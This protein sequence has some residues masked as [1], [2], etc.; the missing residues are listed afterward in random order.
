MKLIRVDM[1]RVYR[2]L[3]WKNRKSSPPIGVQETRG[4]K[5]RYYARVET[6]GPCEITYDD[7]KRTANGDSFRI[8]TAGT[9]RCYD[10]DG[11]LVD[12]YE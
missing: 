5:Y 9:V 10:M 8:R 1:A 3:C 6:D 4:C 2:N 12:E 11:N 7:K